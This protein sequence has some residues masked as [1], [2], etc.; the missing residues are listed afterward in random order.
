MT[1]GDRRAFLV[2]AGSAFEAANT[3]P[4][5]IIGTEGE[6]ISRE[7]QPGMSDRVPFSS[8]TCQAAIAP[9]PE[10]LAGKSIQ[11]RAPVSIQLANVMDV[12]CWPASGFVLEMGVW[13]SSPPKDLV[14]NN[15]SAPAFVAATPST[16]WRY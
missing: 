5:M 4:L 7:V 6:T 14:S 16:R 9:L 15:T 11:R 10:F 1:E 13:W 12:D 8:L 2:S 3:T